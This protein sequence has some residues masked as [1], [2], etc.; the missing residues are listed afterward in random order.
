MLFLYRKDRLRQ[1]IS[2]YIG[3]YP[4]LYNVP[5]TVSDEMIKDRVDTVPFNPKRIANCLSAGL[6]MEAA[7]LKFF[8]NNE[9]KY[10]RL[11][12]EELVSN[13]EEVIDGLLSIFH[14]SDENRRVPE[15]PMKKVANEKN[16]EFRRM[17]IDFLEGNDVSDES[18]H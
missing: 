17:F 6:S 4:D 8:K 15:K 1:A 7:W 2:L 3:Q 10:E 11:A 5:A 16:E 14:V 13:Y 18:R 12:Y 9:I